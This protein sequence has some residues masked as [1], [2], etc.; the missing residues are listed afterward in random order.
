MAFA[1]IIMRVYDDDKI[2]KAKNVA[3]IVGEIASLPNKKL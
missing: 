2:Q 3:M 1:K